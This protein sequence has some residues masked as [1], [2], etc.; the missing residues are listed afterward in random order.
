MEPL[1]K[2]TYVRDKETAKE[3]YRYYMYQ[4]TSSKFAA[5][6]FSVIF[7]LSLLGTVLLATDFWF[8]MVVSAAVLVSSYLLYQRSILLMVKR[9]RE[10]LGEKTENTLV[11]DTEQLKFLE[12]TESLPIEL[13]KIKQAVQTKHY[14]LLITETKM[15]ILLHR[16]GFTLGNEETFRSF[17][18]QKNIPLKTVR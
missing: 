13:S 2:N 18:K 6:F 15:N 4:K 3:F 7:G 5:I 17:L 1:F 10:M 16:E 14:F 9:D 12:P 8:P 11:V